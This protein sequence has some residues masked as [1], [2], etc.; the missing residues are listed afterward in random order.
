MKYQGWQ[1]YATGCIIVVVLFLPWLVG[2]WTIV[3]W[4]IA[5]ATR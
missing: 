3:S 4:T 2:V 1:P 5:G